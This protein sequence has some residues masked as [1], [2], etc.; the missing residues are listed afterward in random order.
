MVI[1]TEQ[2][3]PASHR[4]EGDAEGAGKFFHEY[5]AYTTACS[6]VVASCAAPHPQA[7]R[8]F[9]RHKDRIQIGC[10]RQRSCFKLVSKSSLEAPRSMHTTEFRR[11]FGQTTFQPNPASASSASSR[12]VEIGERTPSSW[13]GQ[14]PYFFHPYPLIGYMS[15]ASSE[16]RNRSRRGCKGERIILRL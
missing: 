15:S 12:E 4:P 6:V 13:P 10:P 16:P 8:Q 5:Y 1:V 14:P 11:T 9:L 2:Q 7:G 3:E